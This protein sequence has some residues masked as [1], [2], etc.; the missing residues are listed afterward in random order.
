[1]TANCNIFRFT[2]SFISHQLVDNGG[3]FW[4]GIVGTYASA[5]LT[6]SLAIKSPWNWVGTRDGST[7][8][9]NWEKDFTGPES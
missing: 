4:L 6:T 9:T 2:Q 7:G 3:D 5:G 8:Y 1:M